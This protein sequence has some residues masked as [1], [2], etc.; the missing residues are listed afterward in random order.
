ML[1]H[2]DRLAGG[3]VDVVAAADVDDATGFDAKELLV[4]PFVGEEANVLA[5]GHPLLAHERDR[6]AR[7]RLPG[8]ER[9][10]AI[11]V[12]DRA[13][14]LLDQ[15]AVVLLQLLVGHGATVPEVLRRSAVKLPVC[16]TTGD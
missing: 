8:R 7:R 15:E 16:Q 9:G 1:E 4:L 13:H 11:E 6:A 2:A 12:H 5:E 3:V 10:Y 14:E